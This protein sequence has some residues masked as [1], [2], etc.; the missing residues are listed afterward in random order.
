MA[1]TVLRVATR[2]SETAGEDVKK[3]EMFKDLNNND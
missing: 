3:I 1:M 2:L